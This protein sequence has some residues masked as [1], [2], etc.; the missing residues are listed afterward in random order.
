MGTLGENN[1]LKTTEKRKG[2][3]GASRFFILS[4]FLVLM[5]GFALSLPTVDV[6]D[7]VSEHVSGEGLSRMIRALGPGSNGTPEGL[8]TRF[9]RSD[10]EDLHECWYCWTGIHSGQRKCH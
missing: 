3:M 8:F 4:T 10:Q 2:K 7:E 6:G 5:F 1:Q 9:R